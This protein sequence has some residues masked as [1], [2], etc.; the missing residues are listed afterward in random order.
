MRIFVVVLSLAVLSGCSTVP[1]PGVVSVSQT[2]RLEQVR[3]AYVESVR[4]VVIEPQAG[5]GALAGTVVGAVAGSSI[6][7]RRDAIVGATLGALA[8]AVAGKALEQGSGARPG[9]EIVL[10][11]ENGSLQSIIQPVEKEKFQ[12]GE[13]VKIIGLSGHWRVVR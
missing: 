10:R 8:G 6:G 12:P 5:G 4:D 3:Y 2:Q 1:S 7:G 9:Q 13:R 11:L